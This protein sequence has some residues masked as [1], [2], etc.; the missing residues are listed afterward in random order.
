[1]DSY[2]SPLSSRYA[3]KEMSSLFSAQTRFRT[4]RELW[5]TLAV[6]QSELGLPIPQAAITQMRANLVRSI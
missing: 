3:S 6:A 1:M 2:Q 5:L 4:W